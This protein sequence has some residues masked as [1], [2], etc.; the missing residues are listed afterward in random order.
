[1]HSFL[2]LASTLFSITAFAT[3]LTPRQKHFIAW[4]ETCCYSAETIEDVLAQQ[5]VDTFQPKVILDLPPFI[6][7]ASRLQWALF[8]VL[9]G[10][11]VY[12]TDIA[13]QYS[14][15]EEV[16]PIFGKSP[17]AKDLILL[18]VLLLGPGLYYSNKYEG[19]I[20]DA[21]LAASN[22]LMTAVVAN[23]F[24][25]YSQAKKRDNCIKIR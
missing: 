6:E 15:I 21:D 24:D 3:D 13:L 20:T 25:V 22:Y 11:D 12:T 17:T 5:H 19:I 18:K 14:C 9:Q 23:N 2:I 16:N 4:G 1:M 8:Y 7:P 10:L